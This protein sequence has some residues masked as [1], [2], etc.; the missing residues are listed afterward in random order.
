MA[1]GS[2]FQVKEQEDSAA[3]ALFKRRAAWDQG[4]AT[5]RRIYR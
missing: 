5:T 3:L 2:P 4:C 1:N